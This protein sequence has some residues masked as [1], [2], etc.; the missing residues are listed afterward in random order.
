[1]ITFAEVMPGIN[2]SEPTADSS[3]A[4]ELLHA[5]SMNV[6]E[7][8]INNDRNAAVP[9]IHDFDTNNGDQFDDDTA[10]EHTD[11]NDTEDDAVLTM[12]PVEDSFFDTASVGTDP[13]AY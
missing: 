3:P 1:V 2:G 6:T 8:L 12:E 10:D 4:Q 11:A 5:L 13:T 9:R 7:A